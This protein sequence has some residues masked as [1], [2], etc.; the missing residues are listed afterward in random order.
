LVNPSFCLRELAALPPYFSPRSFKLLL[1]LLY[2]VRRGSTC[3]ARLD[4][5]IHLYFSHQTQGFAES[6]M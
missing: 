4:T 2:V 3:G 6:V 5:E 1:R